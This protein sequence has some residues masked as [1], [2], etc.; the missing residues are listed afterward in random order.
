MIDHQNAVDRMGGDRAVT[1]GAGRFVM[2]GMHAAQDLA[3]VVIDQTQHGFP[4]EIVRLQAGGAVRII[5]RGERLADPSGIGRKTNHALGI[6]NHH[7]PDSLLLAQ[8]VHD[9]TQPVEVALQHGVFERRLQQ[10]VD[11]SGQARPLFA[12]LRL[13]EAGE[14]QQKQQRDSEQAGCGDRCEFAMETAGDPVCC[15]H[16]PTF[17]ESV[18]AYDEAR[19]G[20]LQAIVPTVAPRQ[21]KV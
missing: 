17:P 12:D 21:S 10:P 11:F 3:L 13:I 5:A 2:H 18:L 9:F 6:E 14:N 16:G 1:L 15:A 7:Q 8:S 19:R 4:G 20:G